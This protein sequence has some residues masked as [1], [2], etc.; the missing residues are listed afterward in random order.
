MTQIVKGSN[1]V[2]IIKLSGSGG[3]PLDLT[4]VYFI[5]SCFPGLDNTNVHTYYASFTGNIA[6][7]SKIV[8]S[9]SN[10]SELLE[11]QLITGA[12]IPLGSK[13]V[14]TPK[15]AV[16]TIAG[17]IEISAAATATTTALS[18][19]MGTIRPLTPFLLGKV[20]INLSASETAL[21]DYGS[22]LDFELK[23]IKAGI[24]SIIQFQN[25]L[26]I[27]EAYCSN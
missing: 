27:L 17:T 22:N 2:I 7:G 25:S 21:L 14:R 19:T 26:E 6:A 9:I 5:R 15:S 13:I 24:T 18:M 11:G 4:G 10:D 8:A 23:I 12:G 3:D 20:E 16:P 1:K